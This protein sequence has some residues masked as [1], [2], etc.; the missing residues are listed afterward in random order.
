VGYCTL[1]RGMIVVE[2]FRVPKA[3]TVVNELLCVAMGGVIVYCT[4]VQALFSMGTGVGSLRLGIPKWPF[5]LA[6][7]FGYLVMSVALVLNLVQDLRAGGQILEEEGAEA[8]GGDA[9]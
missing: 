5:M 4:T 2:L 8:E 9:L 3:V 6:T 1:K 7:A